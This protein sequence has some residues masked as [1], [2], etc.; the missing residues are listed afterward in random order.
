MW[1]SERARRAAG[2]FQ[3]IVLYLY[4]IQWLVQVTTMGIFS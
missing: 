1:L 3:L 4:G 2:I